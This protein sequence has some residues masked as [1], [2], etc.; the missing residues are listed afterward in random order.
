MT[1]R[2]EDSMLI[3]MNLSSLL[4]IDKSK[5]SAVSDILY[6]LLALIASSAPL[7]SMKAF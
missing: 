6:Y 4:G 3:D 5:S 7:E 2:F 1:L